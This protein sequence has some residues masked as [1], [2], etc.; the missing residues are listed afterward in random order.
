M[1]PM[2]TY[3]FR[4]PQLND[5]LAVHDLIAASPPLD[6]NTSYAYYLICHDF[7]Q[8]SVIAEDQGEVVGFISG[9]RRPNAPEVLF[10]WQ[11]VVD[12]K[13]RGQGLAGRMLDWLIDQNPDA[14]A[15]ET[16]IGPSNAASNRL[17]TSLA[18]R[19]SAQVEKSTFLGEEQFGASGHEE[20]VLYHISPL[21]QT[22]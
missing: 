18:E 21:H 7:N 4:K 22:S 3:H 17:F 2:K 20:E 8:T 12:S 15:L 10:I 13:Q 5:G 16:T 6:C 11:V 14:Q 1:Q 9:Y 19:R